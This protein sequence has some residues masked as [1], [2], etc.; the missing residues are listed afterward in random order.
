MFTAARFLPIRHLI[1]FKNVLLKHIPEHPPCSL[2]FSSRAPTKSIINDECSLI[3]YGLSAR[4]L[5]GYCRENSSRCSPACSCGKEK[6]KP[7][8]KRSGETCRPGK[9]SRKLP[10]GDEGHSKLFRYF[11][12]GIIP[13]ILL[14]SVFTLASIGPHRREPF[15]KYTYLRKRDKKF[16][17]GD[18]N[19]TFFHNRNVN[20]LPEGYEDDI[21]R[22][23]REAEEAE[24]KK[25][26]KK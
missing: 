22:A 6:P 10:G 24:A 5:P 12:F 1:R 14:F 4:Q 25:K 7:K 23:Q 9:S 3:H 8:K 20:P 19:K 13:I 11:S 2:Q 15:V 17:W 18:G 26:K 16:A 21:E